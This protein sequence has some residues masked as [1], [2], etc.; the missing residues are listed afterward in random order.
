[1]DELKKLEE[2]LPSPPNR[3]AKICVRIFSDC[4]GLLSSV[5]TSKF[6][7]SYQSA[8][9]AIVE[10]S[11][12][13]RQNFRNLFGRPDVIVDL[14]V[15][16]VLGH[17]KSLKL[18]V[19]ADKLAGEAREEKENEKE[20][21][22]EK[23]ENREREK[24]K[25]DENNDEKEEENVDE[26]V[27]ENVDEKVEEKEEQNYEQNEEQENEQE[28]EEKEDKEAEHENEKEKEEE[29]QVETRV[30]ED[31]KSNGEQLTWPIP[32]FHSQTLR[33]EAWRQYEQEP[34]D[35][36]AYFPDPRRLRQEPY[37]HQWLDQV[38]Q[39]PDPFFWDRQRGLGHHFTG[40]WRWEP[41]SYQ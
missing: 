32:S 23:R 35:R 8:G 30:D 9:K 38:Q 5:R 25:N 1:M 37:H 16:W 4:R 27:D 14:A 28:K 24:E 13:F 17:D 19:Q 33:E 10:K 39:N 15:H 31:E 6:A 11:E 3:G 34:S 40:R 7:A 18:H 26:K 2:N 41:A 29:Q 12:E 22:K 36:D 21:E 20:E